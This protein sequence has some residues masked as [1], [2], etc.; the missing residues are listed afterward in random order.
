MRSGGTSPQNNN[1]HM[2]GSN[3][4]G[5]QPPT[6]EF[7]VRPNCVFNNPALTLG[8]QNRFVLE[9]FVIGLRESASRGD[10]SGLFA[11]TTED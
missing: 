1:V 11:A 7:A 5:I 9:A 10:H 2:V 3:R 4:D 6:L 8:E